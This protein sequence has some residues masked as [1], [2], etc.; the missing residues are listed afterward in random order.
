MPI[1]DVIGKQETVRPKSTTTRKTM[2]RQ[3]K[4]RCLAF[5]KEDV[6]GLA[7]TSARQKTWRTSEHT[8]VN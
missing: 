4:T 1:S 2:T 3:C 8:I 6:K 7:V 5:D